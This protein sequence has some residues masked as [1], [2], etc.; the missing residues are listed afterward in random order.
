MVSVS[1]SVSP[2]VSVSASAVSVS[3]SV[4]V[5]L[6]VLVS[7]SSSVVASEVSSSVVVSVVSSSALGSPAPT[8]SASQNLRLIRVTRILTLSPVFVL[9]TKTTRPLIRAMPSPLRLVS[10]ISTSYSLPIST[11]FGGNPGP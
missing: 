4:S 2:S 5:L 8:T 9:G 10:W 3:V 6:S 7:V 11:G 1:L